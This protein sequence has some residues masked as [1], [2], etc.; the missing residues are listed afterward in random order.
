MLIVII[1]IIAFF[2]LMIYSGI[3][4]AGSYPYAQTYKFTVNKDTLVSAIKTF[5]K[6]NPENNPP[7][8]IGLTDGIDEN[9]NFYNCWVYYPQQNEIVYFVV[10]ANYDN[11]EKSSVWL[12]SINRGLTL[13]HWRTINDDIGR[14]E[15]MKEKALFRAKI[16]DKLKLEYK[17]DGNNALVFWK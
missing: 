2:V 13:G 6:N 5:K 3:L 1:S 7:K 4:G 8:E 17:D 12:V 14:S 16:L 15:N 10:V 9:G 11:V